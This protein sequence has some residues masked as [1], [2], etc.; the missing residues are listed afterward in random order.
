MKKRPEI[1]YRGTLFL[2]R[3]FVVFALYCIGVAMSVILNPKM[4]QAE[5]KARNRIITSGSFRRGD[6]LSADGKPL[7]PYYPEYVLYADF[8]VGI[9]KRYTVDKS[10]VSADAKIKNSVQLDTLRINIYREFAG[11]L[12][13]TVGGAADSYYKMLYNCRVKAEQARKK[14][15]VDNRW[16]TERILKH[17]INVFQRDNILENPFLRKRGRNVTGIY[18][19][20]TG[21]RTYPFGE[22]FA[23]S[24]I[25]VAGDSVASGIESVYNEELADGDN[26]LT[27]VDTR[28]QD[29]CE[30]VL[31]NK[32]AEDLRLVGG[33]I[34][35]MDVATG[36]IKAMANLGAYNRAE[37]AGVHDVFNNAVKAT[38]EPG[39]TFK[40]VSLMLALE[41]GKVKLSDKF[42]THVWRGTKFAGESS[43]DTFL[44]VSRIIERS[45]NV[46]TGNMVDKAFDRNAGKFIQAVK[47]LKIIDNIGNLDE[48]RPSIIQ[49]SSRETMLKISHGYQVKLAPVHILSFYNAIAN[50]GVMV[51]PRLVNGVVRRATGE[52]EMFE[53]E[54]INKSICSRSTLDSVRLALSRVVGRG[55]G[56]RIAGTPYGIVGKT[57]TAKIWLEGSKTYET[58]DGSRELSSFCGYFPQKNPKYSCMVVLY[59]KFLSAPDMKN[60]SAS[61]TAVPLFKKVSD[62]IYSLYF[63]RLFIPANAPEYIPVIKNTSAHTLS[64]LS[65]ELGLHIPGNDNAW[66][67]VDTANRQLLVSGMTLKKGI[68]PDVAGMGLR[69]AVFLLENRGMKVSRSGLGKVVRQSPEPGTVYSPG[70]SIHLT[71]D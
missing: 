21:R 7:A 69:D 8:G 4:K 58:G 64:V 65:A 39:S 1:V 16:Y 56:R 44:T 37:Y 5:E 10:R 60:F 52:T 12:A 14:T 57:G 25:G 6:I 19:E 20:E 36:D 18:T 35:V 63:D 34:I 68:V 61:S 23:H 50:N 45:V 67:K 47:D 40:T 27:T 38:V 33:T 22:D 54:I 53:P 59:T 17:R 30:T 26:I 3:C 42:N 11:L 41:T 31:R 28:I 24:A 13:K 46:G 2:Y 48:T 70:Q 43:L 32:I 55:S 29:I 71:L 9:G 66:V 15:T 51:R 62:K 49:S